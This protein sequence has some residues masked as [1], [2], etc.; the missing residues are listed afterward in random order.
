MMSK[1]EHLTN[2]SS[3]RVMPSAWKRCEENGGETKRF[4]FNFISDAQ[5]P[6]TSRVTPLAGRRE[7]GCANIDYH[8]YTYFGSVPQ[9]ES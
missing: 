2:A 7:N 4:F 8:V 6:T 9:R 1:N 5:S 3:S